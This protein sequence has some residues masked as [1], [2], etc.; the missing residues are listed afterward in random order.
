VSQEASLNPENAS[1]IGDF[2]LSIPG[3][4]VPCE[5]SRLGRSPHLTE[6]GAL[7][8]SLSNRISDSTLRISTPLCIK[9]RSSNALNG[10]R[11][12]RLFNS[13]E[14]ASARACV[15]RAVVANHSCEVRTRA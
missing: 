8:E 13:Y 11:I 3:Y 1:S 12:T 9:I 14:S 4:R 6:P 7:S 10:L 15:D 2:T 5:G